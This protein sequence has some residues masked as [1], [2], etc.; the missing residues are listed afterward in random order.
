MAIEPLKPLKPLKPLARPIVAAL[1]LFPEGTLPGIILMVSAVAA[2]AVANSPFAGFYEHALHAQA[3]PLS[4][5]E[6]INDGLMALF[7]FQVGLEVK[8]EIIDGDLSSAEARRIPVVAAI[9]GMIVPALV[10]L[11]VAGLGSPLT[12]GWAIS[13]ATD[14]AFALGV[15]SLLGSRVPGSLKL[16]LTTIAIADDMGAVAIIALGYTAKVHWLAL[17]AA[18]ALLVALWL[19]HRRGVRT[20]IPYLALTALLWIAMFSSGVHATVA[21]VLGAFFVPLGRNGQ[22]GPLETLEHGLAPWISYAVLPIFGFANAGVSFGAA[23]LLAPLPLAVALGLFLGKQIGVFGGLRLM[24]LLGLGH[25][26]EGASWLHL[27]GLSLL[28][29]IGFTMSLFIGGLAFTDQMLIEEAKI[30]VLAG[31]LLSGLSGFAVLWI[32]GGRRTGKMA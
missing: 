26:P 28:A 32:A 13:S 22:R 8:R 1:E 11:A 15:L 25:R 12:R 4:W 19:V 18:G 31:S 27:Y 29:G 24:A 5:H 16:L 20:P 6:W 2:L 7:F 21:G 23:P 30:G 17:A 10:Y 14:I 3:G 9:S